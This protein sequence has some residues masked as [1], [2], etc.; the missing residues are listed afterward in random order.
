MQQ[1]GAAAK[2]SKAGKGSVDCRVVAL[3]AVVVVAVQLLLV[4][5]LF[6]MDSSASPS[7]ESQA[8]R[9]LRGT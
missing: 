3:L 1:R 5:G 6:F 4:V 2:A 9:R 8:V 7:D